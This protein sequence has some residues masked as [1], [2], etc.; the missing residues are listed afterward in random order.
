MAGL[1]YG[2]VYFE[3]GGGGVQK[4][5]ISTHPVVNLIFFF[6]FRPDESRH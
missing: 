5:D 1:I 3:G 2:I 4:G 6:S